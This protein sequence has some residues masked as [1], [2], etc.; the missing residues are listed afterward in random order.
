MFTC[1][2]VKERFEHR[3]LAHC[4]KRFGDRHAEQMEQN[5]K[6]KFVELNYKIEILRPN[7]NYFY[8]KI[9]YSIL[10]FLK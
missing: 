1:L 5:L 3:S 2:P 4:K 6:E 8:K 10:S 7:V 9:K